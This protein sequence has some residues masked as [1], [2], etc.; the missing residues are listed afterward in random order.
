MDDRNRRK[1]PL[2]PIRESVNETERSRRVGQ[3][4]LYVVD[5][6]ERA[7]RAPEA[8]SRRRQNDMRRMKE[9][10]RQ[11]AAEQ[12]RRRAG[13][14][15]NRRAGGP[16]RRP[17]RGGGRNGKRKRKKATYPAAILWAVVLGLILLYFG[18][19][20][21]TALMKQRVPEVRVEIGSVEIPKVYDGIVIRDEVVQRS[22]AAGIVV[23]A[24]D[25]LAHVNKGGDIYSIQDAEKMV[26]IEERLRQLNSAII[27]M[28][29]NREGMSVYDEEI[30]ESNAQIK[31]TV[32]MAS[33]Q[34]VAANPV[35]MYELADSVRQGLDVRNQRLL[36]E[37][38][39]S[40]KSL[41]QERDIY[42]S[43]MAGARQN[44]YAAQSGVVSYI[45]D[46]LE[47]VLTLE[48]R[49]RLTKEQTTMKVDYSALSYPKDVAAGDVICKIVQSNTWYI[50]AYVDRKSAEG[51][52][53][54]SVRTL[55]MDVEG[56]L[57][58][59]EVRVDQ[60]VQASETEMYVVF[61]CTRQMAEYLN[62]RNVK[63]RLEKNVT[64]GLKI[65]NTAIA[66]RT[67]LLIPIECRMKNAANQNIVMRRRDGVDEPIRI[68][69][70]YIND[71]VCSVLLDDANGLA[72][73]DVLVTKAAEGEESEVRTLAT[74]DSVKGVYVTNAGS[75]VFRMIDLGGNM[76]SNAVYT[77]LDPAVNTDVQIHDKIVADV[78]GVT[79]RQ[80]MQ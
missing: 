19:Y 46:G 15:D 62:C 50:A 60:I 28:Q 79:D 11:R 64:E 40:L 18:G 63:F 23:F 56:Q 25:D 53:E 77:V 43:Q 65:P 48:S 32:D 58:P 31:K 1:P 47:E 39:G 29:E 68:P 71:T 76:T 24:Q 20:A 17:D 67:V 42:E 44:A 54:D 33:F 2:R 51:W 69:I 59:M 45:T 72:L 26:Q 10:D 21:I 36:S 61:R 6:P 13:S 55:Y 38:R 35:R 16:E 3:S 5:Q 74:L 57:R 14:P 34:L 4:G 12:D 80:L 73:G 66:D 52:S 37:N 70:L 8:N 75:T 78:K 22:S 49:E 9:A 27:G 7:R 41:V 30:R